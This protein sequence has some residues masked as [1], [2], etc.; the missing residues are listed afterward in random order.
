M[1]SCYEECR[2]PRLR[3]RLLPSVRLSASLATRILAVSSAVQ[4]E[5]VSLGAKADRV[6]VRHVPRRLGVPA[7]PGSAARFR[8]THGFTEQEVV[9]ATIGHAVPVK[10]WD[11]LIPAFAKVAA[12][13]PRARLVLA[14]SLESGEEKICHGLLLRQVAELGLGGKVIFTAHAITSTTRTHRPRRN[15]RDHRI[16]S[17]GRHMSRSLPMLGPITA[18]SLDAIGSLTQ[19]SH[20]VVSEFQTASARKAYGMKWRGR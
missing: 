8:Q 15:Q 9:I 11:V 5:L 3:D 4:D 20:H 12:V 6:L 17:H 19:Y 14:G 1:N 10:A 16:T 2:R 18:K 7:L 13:E